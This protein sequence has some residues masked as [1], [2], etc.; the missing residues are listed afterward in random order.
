[1]LRSV[2]RD[3]A[4]A[5]LLAALVT[6]SA[7]CSSSIDRDGFESSAFCADDHARL[8]ALRVSLG[9]D[10]VAIIGGGSDQI[11]EA[12]ACT[13]TACVAERE[14]AKSPSSDGS[15]PGLRAGE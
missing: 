6:G 10:W 13:A 12:G 7:A 3:V 8:E 5:A 15:F 1:M 11:I 14:K 4:R 2:L 9:A